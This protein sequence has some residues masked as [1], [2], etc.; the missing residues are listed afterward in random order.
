MTEPAENYFTEL[1]NIDVSGHVKQKGQF[2]YLSWPFAIDTLG[3]LHPHADITVRWFPLSSNPDIQVPYLETPLGYFVEV[4]ITINTVYRSQLHPVLDY[5]NQ[6]IMSPTVFDINTSIQRALVKCAALHGL[7][8]FIYAG[9]D[10]PFYAPEF[11][12]EE[13]ET[14]DQLIADD[15][16]LGLYVFVQN[17]SIGANAALIN[18]FPKGEKGKMKKIACD[19]VNKGN[20]IARDYVDRCRE[21]IDAGDDHGLRQEVEEAGEGA[22]RLIWEQLSNEHQ[23]AARELLRDA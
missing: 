19:L 12:A 15:D 3:R 23:H 14:F 11:T 1:A 7:G 4:A 5:R 8:L 16:A 2:S 10:L 9:E 21:L 17:I 18:S 13:K 20:E 22:K 6:P